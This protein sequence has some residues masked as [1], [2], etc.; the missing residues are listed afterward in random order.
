MYVLLGSTA[1]PSLYKT[2]EILVKPKP[3]TVSFQETISRKELQRY[4][5]VGNAI[6]ILPSTMV[7]GTGGQGQMSPIYIRG[8]PAQG[9]FVLLDEIP[10]NDVASGVFPLGNLTSQ[11]LEG[12]TLLSGAETLLY[13]GGAVGGVI[14]METQGASQKKTHSISAEGGSFET[15]KG[16][17]FQG[18]KGQTYNYGLHLEGFSSGGYPSQSSVRKRGEENPYT[19]ITGAGKITTAL[20]SSW[21]LVLNFRSMNGSLTTDFGKVRQPFPQ[22]ENKTHTYMGG[23][24]LIHTNPEET[25]KHSFQT[26]LIVSQNFY[27]QSLSLGDIWSLKYRGQLQ[28]TPTYKLEVG[29]ENREEWLK[30]LQLYKGQQWSALIWNTWDKE[31]WN[32]QT[33]VR[34]MG[35]QRFRDYMVY[36]L[37]SQYQLNLTTVKFS[38]KTGV[39][40]PTLYDLFGDAFLIGNA[41]LRP[42]ESQAMELGFVQKIKNINV[43]LIYFRN[44]VNNLIYGKPL[45]EFT[46]KKENACLKTQGIETKGEILFLK[47]IKLSGGYTYVSRHQKEHGPLGV[48]RHKGF[49]ELIWV[50]QENL[51]IKTN[52]LYVG[53]RQAQNSELYPSQIV[54]L[55]PYWVMSVFAAYQVYETMSIYG[56]IENIL[57]HFYEDQVHYRTA[58]RAFYVGFQARF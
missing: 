55:R 2:S 3:Q 44:Q 40:A 21:D 20:N 12:A 52:F 36:G 1:K 18:S 25:R 37:S 39:R 45:S 47:N 58:G 23:A 24:K 41:S 53:S 42:E 38:Y 33:G 57:N 29:V 43:G 17:I 48:P 56:K 28:V 54:N 19:N 34:Y 9:T 7:F 11:S 35:Y 50:P 6:K 30:K 14:L 31:K 49:L 4:D 22:D 51:D 15:V 8:L 5:F 10:L 13:D 32:I 27:N 16:A 26:S 46:F